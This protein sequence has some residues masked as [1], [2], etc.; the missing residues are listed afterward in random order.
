M[1]KNMVDVSFLGLQLIV[2]SSPRG[3]RCRAT[4][5]FRR[6]KLAKLLIFSDRLRCYVVRRDGKHV[7][8]I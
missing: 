7:D 4:L 6:K 2:N 3:A 8:L 5:N 1:T